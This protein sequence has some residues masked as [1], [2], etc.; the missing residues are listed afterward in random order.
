MGFALGRGRDQKA[1]EVAPTLPVSIEHV[2]TDIWAEVLKVPHVGGD[3]N[4]FA[5]GGDSLMAIQCVSRLRDK[6]SIRLTL[7]DFFENG[8][9]A[10]QAALIRERHAAAS[11]LSDR[12]PLITSGHIPGVSPA[13][14]AQE[15][16]PRDHSLPYQLSPLQERLWFMERLNPGQ[17][18]Y[19]EVEAVRLRGELNV[20]ALGAGAERGNRAT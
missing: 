9:V 20:E 13:A 7:T 3:E 17:P 12:A 2:I 15:I 4:F 8:T 5:L 18:V 1:D 16:P 19:N 14:D 6:I 10:E 11:R